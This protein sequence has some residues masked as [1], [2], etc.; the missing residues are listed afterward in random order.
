M[1]KKLEKP[2]KLW[3]Q[4]VDEKMKVVKT[5]GESNK[6]IR[7]QRDRKA[8]KM[9]LKKMQNEMKNK[10]CLDGG[11]GGVFIKPLKVGWMAI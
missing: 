10:K 8:R 3:M 4:K 7:Q 9:S 6:K 11:S 2:S 5:F 1:E